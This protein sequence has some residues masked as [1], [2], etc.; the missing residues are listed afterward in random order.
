MKIKNN[1]QINFFNMKPVSE[2]EFIQ[3]NSEMF[4]GQICL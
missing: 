2:K 1:I 3:I 4:H